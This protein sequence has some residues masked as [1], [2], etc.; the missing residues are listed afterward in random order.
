[1]R[2]REDSPH[3]ALGLFDLDKKASPEEL[4]QKPQNDRLS[5]AGDQE[6]R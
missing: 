3:T 6:P 5:L 1:V 2:K 4:V